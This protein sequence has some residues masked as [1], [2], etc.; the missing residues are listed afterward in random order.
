M[1][2][3]QGIKEEQANVFEEYLVP[4]DSY[5]DEEE[6]SPTELSLVHI[7]NKVTRPRSQSTR[8]MAN[9][10]PKL[11]VTDMTSEEISDRIESMYQK[12]NGDFMWKLIW[13][14][15]VTLVAYV[16]RTSGLKIIL[17]LTHIVTIEYN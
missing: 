7:K 8:L 2:D 13:M 16:N 15:C 3:N 4:I 12:I 1:V 10:G 6:I 14:A 11:D 5:K 17:K 9:N